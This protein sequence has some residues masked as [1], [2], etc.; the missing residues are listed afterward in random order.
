MSS[1]LEARNLNHW[2]TT[3]APK[4]FFSSFLLVEENGT[5]PF[6]PPSFSPLKYEGKY[7]LFLS[8]S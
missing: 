8:F 7:A 2:T 1:A 4:E 3:E 5:Y 6:V